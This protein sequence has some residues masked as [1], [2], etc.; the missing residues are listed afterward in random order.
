[1]VRTGA[2]QRLARQLNERPVCS[3]A[4]G[5]PLC[6]RWLARQLRL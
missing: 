1:M 2:R 6:S 5:C 4:P 3:G